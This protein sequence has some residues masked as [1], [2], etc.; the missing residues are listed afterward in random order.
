MK[1]TERQK[2]FL[3]R[4][5]HSMKPIITVGDKGATESLIKELKAALE[6][7]ELLKIKVRAG[8]RKVRDELIAELATTCDALLVSRVGNVAALYRPHPKK[9]KLEL[10]KPG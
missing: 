9:P 4:T 1:L 2:K 3:R 8:D 10:P 7:H 6:H 5:A